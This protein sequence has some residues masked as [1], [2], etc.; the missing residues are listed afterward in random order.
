MKINMNKWL[1]DYLAAPEKKGIPILSFP[2][3]QLINHS[4][5]EG[6]LYGSYR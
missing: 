1:Q 5:E 3:M 4:V 2:G 6:T